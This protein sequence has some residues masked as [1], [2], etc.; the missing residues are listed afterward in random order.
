[1][2]TPSHSK[3]VLVIEDNRDFVYL[4]CSALNQLG[5]EVDSANNGADGI[6]KAREMKPDI[7]FCDIGLP[8]VNG[9]KVAQA[10]RDDTSLKDVYMIALTGYAGPRNM[11]LA[12]E[13]GFNVYMPKPVSFVDLQKILDKES[14]L[15]PSSF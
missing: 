3:K 7:I 2:S 13:S 5:Y 9:F 8:G 6:E 14:K 11:S 1:M 4:L 15:T 12:T 10:V